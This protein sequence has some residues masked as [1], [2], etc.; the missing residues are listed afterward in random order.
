MGKQVGRRFEVE[1]SN[2]GGDWLE[3][4]SHILNS[5]YVPFEEDEEDYTKLCAICGDRKLVGNT[6]Y[7]RGAIY[8]EHRNWVVCESCYAQ[9]QL[10]LYNFAKREPKWLFEKIER[11]NDEQKHKSHRKQ[12]KLAD[13]GLA[14]QYNR[15]RYVDK[16]EDTET[17]IVDNDFNQGY[18]DIGN[19]LTHQPEFVLEVLQPDSAVD[20]RLRPTERIALNRLMRK[21]VRGTMERLLNPIDNYIFCR[22]V[23]ED[24]S[25]RELATEL[26]MDQSTVS[27]RFEN[28]K[29]ILRDWYN[30]TKDYE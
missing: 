15:Q 1:D 17:F 22:I 14:S 24:Y 28:A 7:V 25:Q 6:I 29:R 19:Q 20:D 18:N 3:F 16:H 27:R 26:E 5:Q 2:S 13:G 30:N 21:E 11:A 8:R 10:W 9:F 12:E 4:G 23:L